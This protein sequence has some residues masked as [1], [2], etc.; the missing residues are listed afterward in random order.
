MFEV[1]LPTAEERYHEIV[2][3]Y[4]PHPWAWPEDVT[5]EVY[6]DEELR[7]LVGPVTCSDC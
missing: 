1:R 7:A 3:R 4:G 2:S 6:A 5:E